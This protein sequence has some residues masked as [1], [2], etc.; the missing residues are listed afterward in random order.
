MKN[1]SARDSPGQIFVLVAMHVDANWRRCR[2]KQP[3]EDKFDDDLLDPLIWPKLMK[4]IEDAPEIIE[5]DDFD[6]EPLF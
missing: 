4:L 2:M 6:P 5:S 3:I 1:G